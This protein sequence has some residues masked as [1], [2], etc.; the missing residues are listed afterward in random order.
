MTHNFFY[1][2]GKIIRWYVHAL[3]TSGYDGWIL[4]YNQNPNKHFG[5]IDP[6]ILAFTL[7]VSLNK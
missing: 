3:L 6:L 4:A 1:L 2:G 5:E 7:H